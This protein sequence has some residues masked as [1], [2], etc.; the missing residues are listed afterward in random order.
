M[1]APRRAE[2]LAVERDP[3]GGVNPRPRVAAGASDQYERERMICPR[4]HAALMPQ[5]RVG[6]VVDVCE[7]CAGLWMDQLEVLTLATE[8]H[9]L[10]R[11]VRAAMTA[12]PTDRGPLV[13][14]RR[15]L[16][17]WDRLLDGFTA[18]RERG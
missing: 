3:S 8:L 9:S 10:Q 18:P 16:A 2:R 14:L 11:D 4:C 12:V 13:R 6:V 5:T 15:R 1:G 7:R 17:A